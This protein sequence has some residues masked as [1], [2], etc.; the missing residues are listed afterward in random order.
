MKSLYDSF[1]RPPWNHQYRSA[2]EAL[3]RFKVVRSL[4]LA[5]PTGAGKTV[6]LAAL[7]KF[8]EDRS[9]NIIVYN[10]RR[11]LTQQTHDVLVKNDFNLGVR[12]ASMKKQQN[13]HAKIQVASIQTDII[14]VLDQGVWNLHDAD[15]VV[16]DE[17]H[18]NM[19]P[20][21]Q[22][23][24]QMYLASGA[25][26]L[27]LTG[28]PV[29]LSSM[30]ADVVA[31]CTNTEL[32]ECGAHIPMKCF[33]VA[34]MDVGQIKKVRIGPSGEFSDKQIVRDLWSQQVVGRIYEEWKRLNPNAAPTLAAAPGVGEA[35]WIADLFRQKG[36]NVA[37]IDAKEVIVNGE[38]YANDSNG[39]VR[40]QV[41]NDAKKGAF[42]IVCNCEVLQEGFDWPDLR[43]VIVA[44][45]YASL[46]NFLQVA[47]RGIRANADSGKDSCILQDHGGNVLRHGLPN[48]DRDWEKLFRMSE[49]EIRQE[50]K[51]ECESNPDREPI[52]CPKC[53]ATRAE[54]PRCP[55]CGEIA[56]A[57]VRQIIQKD[58]TLQE[59]GPMFKPKK[60]SEPKEVKQLEDVFWRLKRRNSKRPSDDQVVAVYKNIYSEYPSRDMV[61]RWQNYSKAKY[62]KWAQRQ[63]VA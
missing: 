63:G 62:L 13:L 46:A 29:G 8:F 38:R 54:G 21:V 56:N 44:R 39:V 43:H 5:L 48:D 60:Q 45:P 6:I 33:S 30:Y 28:T 19:G 2:V 58:G 20:R 15:L 23:L 16:V 34:E 3:E 42:D 14:R 37:H 27:G 36:H 40:T 31:G 9:R 47:G 61:E 51:R 32:L 17:A 11:T 7:A 24:L 18:K 49:K 55:S 35:V 53:G 22:E 4:V 41:L 50:R 12:A 10:N 26:V 52:V 57:R 1:P 59:V 25:R